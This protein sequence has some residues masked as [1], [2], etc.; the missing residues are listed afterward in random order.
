MPHADTAGA[1]EYPGAPV[2]ESG[3]CV[4]P[5]QLRETHTNGVG[6]C[7]EALE[8]CE[9]DR[10]RAQLAQTVGCELLDSH[11]FE[12]IVQRQAAISPRESISRQ[13]VIGAAAVVAH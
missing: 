7:I 12:E 6:V 4:P 2:R 1:T 9:R 3:S 11:A 5:F 10:R 13:H 8:C